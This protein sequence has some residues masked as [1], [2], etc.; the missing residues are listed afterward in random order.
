MSKYTQA[1]VYTKQT[2][3]MPYFDANWPDLCE[4]HGCDRASLERMFSK[5]KEISL[6]V[7]F[8][9]ENGKRICRIKCPINPLPVKGEFEAPSVNA[10]C[11]FLVYNGWTFKQKY[12]LRLFE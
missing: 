10:V 1:I 11:N 5:D 12:N 7:M 3:L 6:L 8:R 4:Q 2:N 9:W